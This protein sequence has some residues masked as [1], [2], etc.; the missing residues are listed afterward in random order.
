MTAVMDE[1]GRT[2]V[3]NWY[4]DSK[5]LIAQ[6]F[7]NGDVYWYRYERSPNN[8]YA[9]KVV[10]T[11]PDHSE[12]EISPAETVPDYIRSY[13]GNKSLRFRQRCERVQSFAPG[14]TS[15]PL[16]R[17]QARHM[18]QLATER[19]GAHFLP[20]RCMV[21]ASGRSEGSTFLVGLRP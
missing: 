19:Q 15:L 6:V 11:L 7:A 9:E 8:H 12:K 10:V 1:R 21:S 2:L 18:Y 17:S 20:R 13:R 3:R 14:S 4:D 16:A 5:I